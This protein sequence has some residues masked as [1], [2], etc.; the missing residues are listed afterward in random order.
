MIRS[1]ANY[2]FDQL[3]SKDKLI[4][5]NYEYVK[6]NIVDNAVFE[7]NRDFESKLFSIE[8]LSALQI[9]YDSPWPL[10]AII[11]PFVLD[12]LSKMTRRLL[13]LGQLTNIFRLLWSEMKNNRIRFNQSTKLGITVNK[14]VVGVLD[15]ELFNLL[16]AIQNI[17]Q[18]IL[19]YLSE[20]IYFYRSQLRESLMNCHERGIDYVVM[21][22]SKYCNNISNSSLQL[23][24]PEYSKY[25]HFVTSSNGIDLSELGSSNA[26][27]IL[28]LR[29]NRLLESCR[30]SLIY[31]NTIIHTY[32][33]EPQR[34]I[35][36]V[37]EISQK[38]QKEKE[39]LTKMSKVVVGRIDQ[40]NLN[41]LFNFF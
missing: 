4:F 10:P 38:L 39:N 19:N 36:L 14:L 40:S 20:R 18:S 6:F 32:H 12:N 23:S 5:N 26:S 17:V 41:S 11:T 2:I 31:L 25:Q 24:M 33:L 7:N 37:C 30:Q 1:G 35:D 9:E 16:R 22:L 34:N 8:G 3:K 29:L 15:R 27:L 21:A 13:E 28:K